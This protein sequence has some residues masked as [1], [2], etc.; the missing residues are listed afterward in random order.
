MTIRLSIII[1][2]WNQRDV[3]HR[4]LCS[5]MP[6]IEGI[7]HEVIVVD[8]GSSD[9]SLQML[10]QSFPE[11]TVIANAENR[12]VAAARNQGITASTGRYILIL[13]N[14]TVVN[15][16]AIIGMLNY[17]KRNP[18]AGIVACRLLNADSSVQNSLKPYPCLKQKIRNVLRLATH[19]PQF[20]T[21]A[22]GVIHPTYVIGACQ[23]F[24]LRIVNE[25]GL[26]DEN[27]FYGPEDA[28]FC[29]RVAQAGY[30]VCYLPMYSIEHLHRRVT[31]HNLLSPLARRHIAALL[32]FYR[33]HRRWWQ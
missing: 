29:L 27:I 5:L 15:A 2:T 25:V 9:G 17:L 28:D 24:S 12:G 1:L 19:E 10:E 13:D 23:M 31:S 30:S 4:C 8:N 11:I 22:D 26:L 6:A 18:K 33:K 3:L 21:D 7:S 20:S 32:Y 14:D 16:K